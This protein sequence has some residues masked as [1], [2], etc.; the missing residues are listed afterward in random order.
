[1][2]NI[3]IITTKNICIKENMEKAIATI[4]LYEILERSDNKDEI[5][6]NIKF[7]FAH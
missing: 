6:D 7:D 4:L 5:L 2:L 1:M 3:F